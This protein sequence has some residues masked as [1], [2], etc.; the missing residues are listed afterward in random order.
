L[1]PSC[2][3]DFSILFSLHPRD[4]LI[5]IPSVFF[6]KMAVRLMRYLGSISTRTVRQKGK[7]RTEAEVLTERAK[8]TCL[9]VGSTFL[10]ELMSDSATKRFL[11]R[12]GALEP[13]IQA[14]QRDNSESL[15]VYPI[16]DANDI[17]YVS[18]KGDIYF[19]K[20][21]GCCISTC[22]YK[23]QKVAVKE[24]NPDALAFKG[25]FWRREVS[26]MHLVQDPLVVKFF[27]ANPGDEDKGLRP[28]MVMELPEKG[29]LWDFARKIG[30]VDDS[31]LA[32]MGMQMV[33]SVA[34]L[35]Q[36]HIIHRDIKPQN[37]LVDSHCGIK[38]IDFGESRVLTGASTILDE[39]EDQDSKAAALTGIR[40]RTQ[41][42]NLATQV[43]FAGTLEFM[44]P[45]IYL[46]RR[47]GFKADVYSLAMVFWC[48]RS[49]RMPYD[50]WPEGQLIIELEKGTAKE[51]ELKDLHPSFEK[52]IYSGWASDQ[53]QR[54]TL[55]EMQ[56]IL[57]DMQDKQ[58]NYICR[59]YLRLT[60][61]TGLVALKKA[62]DRQSIR[63]LS[64]T[65]K[66][67]LASLHIPPPSRPTVSLPP[68]QRP[69][70]SLQPPVPASSGSLAPS[71]RGPHSSA[72]P[73]SLSQ[74]HLRY[75]PGGDDKSKDAAVGVKADSP[76]GSPRSAITSSEPSGSVSPRSFTKSRGKEERAGLAKS[77]PQGW[78]PTSSSPTLLHEKL[79]PAGIGGGP[80]RVSLSTNRM[81]QDKDTPA[82]GS[83]GSPTS[84]GGLSSQTME[85]SDEDGISSEG[86]ESTP[87][88]TNSK[89]L[90]SS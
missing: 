13:I 38:L 3:G 19:Q 11:E 75:T 63:A 21:N 4:I 49:F 61:Q 41:S 27:G 25:P 29:N 14:I 84:G 16:I 80:R 9:C 69:T 10:W 46:N 76:R 59:T 22:L 50:D 56:D 32:N 23:G 51:K 74:P 88:L 87:S 57:W 81:N 30:Y 83:L 89:D 77:L 72:L 17:T 62:L 28:F 39:E 44:A 54:L 20:S 34:A 48:L 42:A 82:G 60:N 78:K 86:S 6:R 36:R 85:V 31:L 37:F 55:E 90:K 73:M 8:Q 7:L 71:S 52:I 18:N 15:K 26:I 67:Y 40:Q 65:C 47:Y 45:E 58:G 53:D 5:L 1:V 68:G 2:L 12:K 24:N 43:T 70:S 79:I 66:H 64:L 33:N 35:Q